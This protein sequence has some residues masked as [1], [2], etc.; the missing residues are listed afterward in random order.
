VEI[1]LSTAEIDGGE[2]RA[3]AERVQPL[4]QQPSA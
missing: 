4:W 2:F 1:P 3:A